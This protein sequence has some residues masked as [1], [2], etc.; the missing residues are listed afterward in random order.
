[1]DIESSL[2]WN[3]VDIDQVGKVLWNYKFFNWEIKKCKIKKFSCML[4][5]RK[6]DEE[7]IFV[8]RFICFYVCGPKRKKLYVENKLLFKRNIL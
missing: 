7:A 8:F 4:C 3:F 1:M 5:I 2:E 6:I